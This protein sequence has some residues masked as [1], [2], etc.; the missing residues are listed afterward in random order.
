MEARAQTGTSG[1]GTA[2]E[3][4]ADFLRRVRS[5]VESGLDPLS[6]AE[7]AA[8]GLPGS[9]RSSIEAT[10]GLGARLRPPWVRARSRTA[11]TA[12]KAGW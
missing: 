6:A 5:G 11:P 8:T 4:L 9:V 10:R 1:N 3:A 12:S 7:R 2:P